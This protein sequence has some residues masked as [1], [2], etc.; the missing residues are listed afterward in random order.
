MRPS[1][2]IALLLMNALWA[3]SYSV[4]KALSA[5]FSAGEIV[6][7]RYAFAA[8]PMVL[9]WRWLPG[10]TPGRA[11]LP[12][13][14][15]MGIVVF[16]LSPR[17]Q[18]EGVRL[19][20]AGNSS[21]LAGLEPLITAVVAAIF[22]REHVPARRWTG[23]AL[24]LAGLVVLYG[25]WQLEI[26]TASF[27]ANLIFISSFFCESGYSVLG[28]PL[29]S[30]FHPLKV[31]ASSLFVGC[32]INLALDGPPAV[33]H[34]PRLTA[35]DW[36]NLLFLSIICTL[37]GYS[38]WFFVIR[39]T[40]VNLAALTILAQPVFGVLVAALFLGESLHW[41]QFWGALV[42]L[43]GLVLGFTRFGLSKPPIQPVPPPR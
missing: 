23:F 35:T 25:G 18:V 36:A 2:L 20:T 32:A 7:W 12:R 22:L 38:L 41:G 15:L 33:A 31:I 17:L 14:A 13:I 24:G 42:I 39:E 8:L 27:L 1:Y 29:L 5:R 4:F 43:A 21:V 30:R 40:D 19:D 6:T 26:R 28:K 3:G 9:L 16:V 34:L 37:V 10:P 11:D